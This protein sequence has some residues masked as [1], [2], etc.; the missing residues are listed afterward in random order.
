MENQTAVGDLTPAVPL[1]VTPPVPPQ[2]S[3]PSRGSSARATPHSTPPLGT[4]AAA[5]AYYVSRDFARGRELTSETA[6]G[7]ELTSE[8]PP[9]GR[10]RAPS[11]PRSIVSPPL[12]TA[13]ALARLNAAES[14][15]A[16][17]S[18]VAVGGAAR[19][20]TPAMES[21]A[22]RAMKKAVRLA[23]QYE[24]VADAARK[25]GD[26]LS[27]ISGILGG[28][29][30]TGG[31]VGA[32]APGSVSLLAIGGGSLSWP[33]LASIVIGYVISVIAILMS[34][35]RLS[36]V[37]LK[38]VA[39]QTGLLNTAREIRWQLAQPLADRADAHEFVHAREA[40]IAQVE[41]AA[42]PR[43]AWVRE[44][45]RSMFLAEGGAKDEEALD[46][47]PPVPTPPVGAL[48]VVTRGA[49]TPPE[50]LLRDDP[51]RAL[52]IFVAAHEAAR[53][54]EPDRK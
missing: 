20:W 44:K 13:A 29:V 9:S 36:E 25:L 49:S 45:Y 53:A 8:T 31:V 2:A 33:T 3:T 14:D 4:A 42:P 37:Q 41:A 27:L 15:G 40:E 19:R 34:N 1:A 48:E 5:A 54:R 43:D 10:S 46:W 18:S 17:D 35:W 30:G 22:R 11:L 32:T 47:T 12:L 50:H 21:L 23:W 7:R 28:L 52:A 6:R 38:G 39:A 16:T 24:A 51:L 26:R